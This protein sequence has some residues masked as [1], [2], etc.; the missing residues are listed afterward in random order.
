MGHQ[1][2]T[3]QIVGARNASLQKSQDFLSSLGHRLGVRT[4]NGK[5]KVIANAASCEIGNCSQHCV[6][7]MTMSRFVPPP[8]TWRMASTAYSKGRERI[9]EITERTKAE[10]RIGYRTGSPT[11]QPTAKRKT[12]RSGLSYASTGRIASSI[13]CLPAPGPQEPVRQCAGTGASFNSRRAQWERCGPL[14]DLRPDTRPLIKHEPD[15][16]ALS[17]NS[18]K[19]QLPPAKDL[20]RQ[21]EWHHQP[22]QQNCHRHQQVVEPDPLQHVAAQRIDRRCQR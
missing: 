12:G 14:P 2:V 7:R 17:V 11:R 8:L 18:C 15:R 6:L 13:A 3:A 5:I 22:C 10:S 9:R 16:S 4:M 20:H 21:G 19:A 1:S